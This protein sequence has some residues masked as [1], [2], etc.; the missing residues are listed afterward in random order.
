MRVAAAAVCHST[1]AVAALVA[2]G[3]T[4]GASM[5]NPFGQSARVAPPATSTVTAGA[6]PA[7]AGHLAAGPTGDDPA[8]RRLAALDE[9]NQQLDKLLAQSRQES[10]VWK[11]QVT[12]LRGRLDD[13]AAQ[14]SRLNEEKLASE[15]KVQS[16]QASSQVAGGAFKPNNSLRRELEPIQLQGVEV[17]V[18]GDVVR[19]ELPADKLFSPGTAQLNA[20]GRSLLQRV[21]AQLV[22]SYR[23]QRIGVEGHTSR[24][25]AG[26]GGNWA[27][28]H[29]LS[30]A[31][32]A[33]VLSHLNI[34]VRMPAGQLFVA[35]HGA[36]LPVMSNGTPAGR[37]RNDRVEL[38]VY[39]DTYTR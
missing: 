37:R 16:L 20:E 19:V 25:D 6:A 5:P 3:C 2:G 10:E 21:A 13:S 33:A 4:G 11:K 27:G 22:R 38:V 39:P 1:L 28:Y 12:E 29:D 7:G 18:D 35:G 8:R 14:L 34:A 31:R 30:V 9:D 36:N 32:A 23:D 24:S 17:R 26:P 15:R